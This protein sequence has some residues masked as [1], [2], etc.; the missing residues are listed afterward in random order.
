MVLS[1]YSGKAEALGSS[2]AS[3]IAVQDLAGADFLFILTS[4]VLQP[5]RQSPPVA[6]AASKPELMGNLQMKSKSPS[7]K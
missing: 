1:L 7:I 6:T 3:T 5:V 2:L 4:E